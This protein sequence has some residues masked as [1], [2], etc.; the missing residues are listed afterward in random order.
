MS[1]KTRV[2]G[3]NL[4]L[5]KALAVDKYTL[6][7]HN[8]YRG[9]RDPGSNLC[10]AGLRTRFSSGDM[11]GEE[12]TLW[13]WSLPE[14]ERD[15]ADAVVIAVVVE[16]F[17]LADDSAF[18]FSSASF[19]ARCSR[20]S[21]SNG[22]DLACTARRSDRAWVCKTEPVAW[23][24]SEWVYLVKHYNTYKYNIYRG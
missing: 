19:A 21:S 23:R 14:L 2:T 13:W 8:T 11:R 12:G 24:R 20:S 1:T 4:I 16:V 9:D 7:V 22:F 5:H 17:E 18:A 15:D 10:D 3:N 6:P